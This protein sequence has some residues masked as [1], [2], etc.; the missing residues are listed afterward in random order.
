MTL[1][2]HK[3]QHLSLASYQWLQ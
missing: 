2:L 1:E 3:L